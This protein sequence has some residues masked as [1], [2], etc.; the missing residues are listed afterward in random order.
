[1]DASIKLAL[2]FQEE[3]RV[4]RA[5]EEAAEAVSIKLARQLQEE[6]YCFHSTLVDT[7]SPDSHH[8][9]SSTSARHV[10]TLHVT[11]LHEAQSPNPC[12]TS[13]SDRP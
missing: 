7:K 12:D 4:L 13:T 2:Q 6:E 3:D 8:L 5:V 1:M 10:T 11:A 9:S